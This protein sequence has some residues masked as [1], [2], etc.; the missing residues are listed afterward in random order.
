MGI[1]MD[2]NDPRFIEFCSR[3]DVDLI[4]FPTNWIDEG[5]PV[6]NYWA[7]LL[8]GMNRA[9]LLAANSYGVDGDYTLSGHSAILQATPPTLL[10]E[11]PKVG[12]YLITCTLDYLIP[13][14][15]TQKEL[16]IE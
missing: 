6:I 7:A 8:Q 13:L 3:T 1:C 15:P 4:A 14:H 5:K 9:T 12:D 10:G 11:A 16:N 2:L